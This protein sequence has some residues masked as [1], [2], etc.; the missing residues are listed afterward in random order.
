MRTTKV[1]DAADASSGPLKPRQRLISFEA[2]LIERIYRIQLLNYLSSNHG[3][4]KDP[5]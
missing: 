4:G 2:S 1:S 5:H 3:K